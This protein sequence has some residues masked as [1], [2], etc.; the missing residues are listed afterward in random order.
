MSIETPE[1]I[2]WEPTDRSLVEGMVSLALNAVPTIK[3]W[4]RNGCKV[5]EVGPSGGRALSEL[6][7]YGV[8][9]W[10]L[11]PGL[12]PDYSAD[13]IQA[14]LKASYKTHGIEDR[15]VAGYAAHALDACQA[16]GIATPFDIAIAFG[17]NWQNYASN[18]PELLA[19][20]AGLLSVTAPAGELIA[21]AMI[22]KKAGVLI[23]M[24][25]EEYRQRQARNENQFKTFVKQPATVFKLGLLCTDLE[26]GFT[27]KRPCFFPAGNITIINS[28]DAYQ[29]VLA[30]IESRQYQDPK[31]WWLSA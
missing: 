25:G 5:L 16:S 24:Y 21:G 22:H 23:P 9:I 1:R 31:Y 17:M 12:L 6:Y 30:A 10:G 2:P 8:N 19:S 20:L 18:A 3:K 13:P 4:L 28:P 15:I 27:T 29:K 11:E 26:I 14:W 7:G